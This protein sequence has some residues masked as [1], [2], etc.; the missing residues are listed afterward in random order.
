MKVPSVQKC[1]YASGVPTVSNAYSID[2]DNNPNIAVVGVVS[3]SITIR[4]WNLII[5]N[6]AQFTFNGI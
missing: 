4:I 3:N 5:P 6:G 1:F 2:L